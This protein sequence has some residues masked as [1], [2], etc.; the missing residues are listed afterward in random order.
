MRK[1]LATSARAS[2]ERA[3]IST[4]GKQNACRRAKGYILY[5]SLV[6]SLFILYIVI[7]ASSNLCDA[8][9]SATNGQ[10]E[11]KT[12][13]LIAP[14]HPL[15]SA[16]YLSL[17]G[18]TLVVVFDKAVNLSSSI[19]SVERRQ[20]A[21]SGVALQNSATATGGSA[22][23]T[24]VESSQRLHQAPSSGSRRVIAP[25]ANVKSAQNK[26]GTSVSYNHNHHIIFQPS[27]AAS[28][29]VPAISRLHPQVKRRSM[30]HD[31][32]NQQQQL[33]Q[34]Q[35]VARP[36]QG[37]QLCAQLLTKKTLKV[38]HKFK[39]HNCIWA[40]ATQFLIQLS[41]PINSNAPVRVAFQRGT[42][43]ELHGVAIN[44]VNP[45]PLYNEKE[46]VVELNKLPLEGLGVS[47]APKLA[48]TGP[49]QVPPCG[50]FSLSAHLSS[51]FGTQTNESVQ[52]QWSVEKLGLLAATAGS[53]TGSDSA[54]Q[55][56][57]PALPFGFT[58][59][60]TGLSGGNIGSNGSS[61]QPVALASTDTSQLEAAIEMRWRTLRELVASNKG[62]NLVLEASL[63]HFVP[64]LY[65]FRVQATFMTTMTSITLN[66]THQ[67]GR[68]DFDTPIGT[69]YS[70]HLLGAEQQHNTNHDLVLLADIQ[71]PECAQNVKQVG[72]YWQVSDPR[73]RFEQTY[74]PYYIARSN[75]LPEQSLIE[76]RLNLFYGIRVK[77][78]AKAGLF[79]ATGDSVLD[80]Q[81]SNG[82]LMESVRQTSD[83]G[84]LIPYDGSTANNNQQQLELYGGSA[85]ELAERIR[86]GQGADMDNKY[87][88]QWSCFD[89][90]TAQPCYKSLRVS[91]SVNGTRY[92]ISGSSSTDTNQQQQQQHSG[93][94]LVDKQRLRQPVLRIP[95]SWLDA[96]AQLWFGLQRFDRQ[97]PSQQSKTEYA[98]VSVQRGTIPLTVAVGPVLIGRSRHRATVRNP[99]TGALI[100]VANAPVVVVGRLGPSHLVGSFT[101][102]IP[103]Y[104]HPLYWTAHNVTDPLSDQ[105]ELVTELHLNPSTLVGHAH[106]QVQLSACPQTGISMSTASVALDIVS[107]VSQCR[108]RATSRGSWSQSVAMAAVTVEQC[109]IPLNLSPITYQ[110]YIV[111]TT[112]SDG[113]IESSRAN[114]GAS[115]PVNDEAVGDEADEASLDNQAQPITMSQ[116]SPVFAL[117]GANAAALMALLDI[118][119]VN[120]N[121]KNATQPPIATRVRFGARVCDKLQSCRMFYSAPVAPETLLSADRSGTSGRLS[122]PAGQST[123]DLVAPST[124]SAIATNDA[125]ARAVQSLRAMLGGARR[126]NLA[127]NSIAAISILNGIINLASKLIANNRDDT[128]ARDLLQ[129]AMRETLQ[130]G[131]QSLQRQFHYTESGQT[132][133]VLHSL[134]R[135]LTQPQ[136]SIEFKYRAIRLMGQ[137]ARR[138]V[139]EQRAA[140][141]GQPTTSTGG[142]GSGQRML[143]T[144]S[145]ADSKA[146]QASFEAL[147]GT[148]SQYTIGAPDSVTPVGVHGGA[149]AAGTAAGSK[150]QT[151]SHVSYEESNRAPAALL[152][153]T[154]TAA[155]LT[156]V[157][158]GASSS[159]GT[160]A[161]ASAAKA[162]K[163]KREDAIL[164]YLR[165]VR[166]AHRA[167]VAAAAVQLP[168]GGAQQFEYQSIEPAG[169]MSGPTD[170]S[171]A[172]QPQKQPGAVT[173]ST[174][175]T[176]DIVSSL[177]RQTEM[178][179]DS[180]DVDLHE[181]GTVSVKF[182]E[183][184]KRKLARTIASGRLRCRN[185]T[186]THMSSR[187]S[188]SASKPTSSDLQRPVVGSYDHRCSSF[189]LAV[190]S[191][192]GKAPFRALDE[193]NM[194]RIPLLDIQW[195]SPVDGSNLIELLR[196][197]RDV[198]SSSNDSP[199]TGADALGGSNAEGDEELTEADFQA[200][201]TFVVPD[202]SSGGDL[203]GANEES[204]S[205]IAA[206]SSDSTGAGNRYKCYQF[207]EDLNEWVAASTLITTRSST[208]SAHTT[209]TE[210]DDDQVVVVGER[211]IRCNFAGFGTLAAFRNNPP[212][213]ERSARVSI[214]LGATGV[215]ALVALVS[216]LGCLASSSRARRNSSATDSNGAT[217]SESSGN[218]SPNNNDVN[219]T[220]HHLSPTGTGARAFTQQH[221][222]SAIPPVQRAAMVRADTFNKDYR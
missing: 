176:A 8:Q 170:Q 56:P 95:M 69:L 82:L 163:R 17:D 88:Y 31:Q 67:V 14:P 207:D 104:V 133:L 124:S 48:L 64:Q 129:A 111:D 165:A 72:A 70:T 87:S 7:S 55:G 107:G 195:L 37:V 41:R 149:A 59:G 128:E 113:F 96:D 32:Q 125:H 78:F 222:I 47:L 193:G 112:A 77:K 201:A 65:E 152:T 162:N 204:D 98:L 83:S 144:N 1:W 51:P 190:S 53:S 12:E 84:T 147:F 94:L 219:V 167:L 97:N 22:F 44:E 49:N 25:P 100:L 50:Q 114:A 137:V 118:Q 9:Q 66:A 161:L 2:F 36:V 93:M 209:A 164:A 196:A 180:I 33:D 106:F 141:S 6:L 208:S 203:N 159:S 75:T 154:L 132:N 157:G 43:S 178:L 79:I 169:Y 119:T 220:R 139:A 76:F 182:D 175:V 171:G 34:Q 18:L 115:T 89:G 52:L 160:A 221:R 218:N 63:L 156:A 185:T 174:S 110:L 103:N 27:A 214:V 101:W 35:D 131:A 61:N 73:V 54:G 177:V 191:F 23:D 91:N 146:I 212:P 198:Q 173:T 151:G 74:A 181:F 130:F 5:Q 210:P 30:C 46:L 60:N 153:N 16:S 189:V 213:A 136:S 3:P 42:I 199:L 28:N 127:G 45:E 126:A 168:L 62:N 105:T 109:N 80:A 71:V 188:H 21:T 4:E 206:T 39:L 40:S 200:T 179:S 183:R 172:D 15:P 197:K 140:T 122:Q 24:A 85:G 120:N 166:Q 138:T 135:I 92:D 90:K 121:N 211:K 150:Q 116:L 68:L 20:A 11:R 26:L 186:T 155:S 158:D 57:R 148:F 108:V 13:K 142:S 184:L 216:L 205:T 117:T 10:N 192:A 86:S 102:R 58:T 217:S 145:L 215:L 202:D 187:W 38:L 19:E 134:A 81:I 29:V 143:P 194:L 123:G 99:L